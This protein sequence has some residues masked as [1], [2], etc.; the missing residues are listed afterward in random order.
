MSEE[1][2]RGFRFLGRLSS[3]VPAKAIEQAFIGLMRPFNGE[4]LKVLI[5]HGWYMI[6]TIRWAAANPGQGYE[7]VPELSPEEILIL[8]RRRQAMLKIGLA[9]LGAAKTVSSKVPRPVAEQYISAEYFRKWFKEK[10]PDLLKVIEGA[11][12][13]G[14]R[15]LEKQIEEL[16]EFFLGRALPYG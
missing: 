15:W 4:H 8:E 1:I 3:R 5:D 16:R 6:E 2:Y 12:A 7:N 9:T 10:R 14:E 13:R 11:G